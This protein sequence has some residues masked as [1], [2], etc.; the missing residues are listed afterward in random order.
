MYALT[1]D[2]GK[3]NIKAELQSVQRAGAVPVFQ[4]RAGVGGKAT[5]AGGTKGLVITEQGPA[6]GEKKGSC[7]KTTAW[8]SVGPASLGPVSLG[9]ASCAP[10]SCLCSKTPLAIKTPVACLRSPPACRRR[11]DVVAA[12]ALPVCS[13]AQEKPLEKLRAAGHRARRCGPR[14][15]TDMQRPVTRDPGISPIPRPAVH[16]PLGPQGSPSTCHPL[17]EPQGRQDPKGK[18]SPSQPTHSRSAHPAYAPIESRLHL[19]NSFPPVLP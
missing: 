10:G 15:N 6:G 9:P 1:Q 19:T 2:I 8:G 3:R 13:A 14:S 12:L 5:G 11:E 16:V 7:Q 17:E 18:V 4:Q